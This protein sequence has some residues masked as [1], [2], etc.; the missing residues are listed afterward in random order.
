MFDIYKTQ[1]QKLLKLGVPVILSQ[2]GIFSVQIFDNAMVGSLGALPL[3]AI[4]FSISVFM[5]MFLGITGLSMSITPLIGEAFAQGKKKIVSSYL[6]NALLL[7]TVISV[8]AMLVLLAIIPFLYCLGQ[9]VEVVDA[10]LPYYRHLAWSIIPYMMFCCF[11][12]FWEGIGNTK[13]N[14][15]IVI[16]ANL[17]NIFLNWLLIFGNWSF[18]RMEAAGAGLAT[19]ISRMC[20]AVFAFI[21]FAVIPKYRG[22]LKFFT[23]RNIRWATNRTLLK[24]GLPISFQFTTEGITITFTAIMV[25]WFGTAAI[26]ANQITMTVSGLVF[27]VA[28]GL[29]AATTICISHEY[30]QRNIAQMRKVSIASLHLV[31]AWSVLLAIV[32]LLFGENIVRIFNDE[33]EVVAIALQLLMFYSCVILFDGLQDVS[34]SQ[35][36]GIQDVKTLMP[37]SV[38]CYGVIQLPLGYFLAFV[39]NIGVLGIYTGLGI[40]LIIA[41][42]LFRLRFLKQLKL[43]ERQYKSIQKKRSLFYV[44]LGS[45]IRNRL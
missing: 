42:T 23:V 20:M 1:Y 31:A 29:S 30:G 45:N 22:Y 34:V 16:I 33:P 10:A 5:V 37:I 38:L 18:P 36:R 44:E 41:F 13:V 27:M 14:M 39:L 43:M 11:E 40:A 6:F 26:A 3:A 32:F 17:I 15:T 2:I 21:W 28:L 8:L 35:L 19:L 7:F 4:S 12:R 24:M 25:G 9:P